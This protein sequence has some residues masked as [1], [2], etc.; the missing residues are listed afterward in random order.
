MRIRT[1]AF[2]ALGVVGVTLSFAARPPVGVVIEWPKGVA[3]PSVQWKWGSGEPASFEINRPGS[4][5]TIHG[6]PREW[7]VDVE[8]RELAEP[9]VRITYAGERGTVAE[10]ALHTSPSGTSTIWVAPGKTHSASG[11]EKFEISVRPSR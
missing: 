1:V 5:V 6:L 11:L 9:R 10:V 7:K 4:L 3:Q 2:V 8:T